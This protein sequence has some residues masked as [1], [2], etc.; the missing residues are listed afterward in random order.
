MDNTKIRNSV[1]INVMELSEKAF[2]QF[3]ECIFRMYFMLFILR[4]K[5]YN[6]DLQGKVKGA[7]ILY[8]QDLNIIR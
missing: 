4:K 8:S 2:K 3:T 7:F 6:S 1:D 5:A